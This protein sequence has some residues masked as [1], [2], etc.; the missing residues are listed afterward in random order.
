M[1][2]RINPATVVAPLGRYSHGVEVAAGARWLF[3]SGQ[4]V[5]DAEG[6]LAEDAAGQFERVFLNIRAIL[7]D[8]GMGPEDLVKVTTFL[9]RRED[10]ETYRE[11]R[12]R[13]LPVSDMPGG[14]A[15]ATLIYVAGL[16]F[17]EWVVEIEA[18]AAKA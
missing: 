11:V 1:H 7:E 2:V 18:I 12:D 13:L 10:V 6:N 5:I 16:A 15:A 14:E 9:T 8:A 17:P 4:V 3:I